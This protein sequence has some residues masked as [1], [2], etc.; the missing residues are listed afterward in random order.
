[1]GEVVWWA[2]QRYVGLKTWLPGI[3]LKTTFKMVRPEVC[4]NLTH[5]TAGETLVYMYIYKYISPNR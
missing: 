5:H 2:E 4:L 1:M 3:I